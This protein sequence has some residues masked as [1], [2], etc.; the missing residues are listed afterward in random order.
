MLE[1]CFCLYFVYCRFSLGVKDIVKT[2]SFLQRHQFHQ[3]LLVITDASWEQ[4][5]KDN[6]WLEQWSW[7][8]TQKTRPLHDGKEQQRKQML[9]QR[10]QRRGERGR[11]SRCLS[12][13]ISLSPW[14]AGF[15]FSS[16]KQV[17]RDNSLTCFSRSDATERGRMVRHL[18]FS[19]MVKSLCGG[20][21]R[22]LQDS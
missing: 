3:R 19:I 18:C 5:G 4:L 6:D 10:T 2:E 9:P 7:G 21:V 17:G 12:T 15:V 11:D 14:G 1:H 8:A 22:E 16:L 13:S 20:G